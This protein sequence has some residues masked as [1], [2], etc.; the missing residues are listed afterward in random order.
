MSDSKDR[1]IRIMGTF[2]LATG[3]ADTMEQLLDSLEEELSDVLGHLRARREWVGLTEQEISEY[4]GDANAANTMY[5]QSFARTIEAKLKE[6]NSW[7]LNKTE[8]PYLL[9]QKEK[10]N[11]GQP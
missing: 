5:V 9:K 8:R 4:W 7:T 3:H 11:E 2:G 10:R 1:L 6:K